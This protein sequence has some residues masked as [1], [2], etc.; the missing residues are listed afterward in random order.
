[1][2]PENQ[3]IVIAK[4]HGFSVIFNEGKEL[5]ELIAPSGRWEFPWDADGEEAHCWSYAPDYLNDLNAMHE[6]WLSIPDEWKSKFERE[7]HCLV[8]GEHAR[9][10]VM[11]QE[12]RVTNASAAQRAEAFLKTLGLWED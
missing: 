11:H 8:I 6:A 10:F 1:M 9:N 7:L 2:T 5:H 4:A 3:R 12:Q